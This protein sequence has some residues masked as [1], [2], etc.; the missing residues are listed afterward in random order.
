M[1]EVKAFALVLHCV[2]SGFN[3]G[4]MSVSMHRICRQVNV[5]ESDYD[6]V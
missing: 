1:L 5:E 3:N 2:G 6:F 4:W